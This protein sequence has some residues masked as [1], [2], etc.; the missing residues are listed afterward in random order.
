MSELMVRLQERYD[1]V[2]Y[3]CAPVLPV[4]DAAILSR[5]VGGVLV[6]ASINQSRRDQVRGA[7]ISLQRVN[8][9]VSGVIAN[10][11]PVRGPAAYLAESYHSQIDDKSWGDHQ[12]SPADWAS[13]SD[14]EAQVS[15]SGA[16]AAHSAD[17]P[18][19]D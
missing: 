9:R 16:P 7:L 3:D 10:R 6:I 8:A 11:L 1:V 13:A 18:V 19:R 5:H 4:P 12:S 15:M 17:G 2:L 14:R